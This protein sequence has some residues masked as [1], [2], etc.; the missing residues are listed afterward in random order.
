MTWDFFDMIAAQGNNPAVAVEN[1]PENM[2]F[3]SWILEIFP[4][5]YVLHIIRDP[6]GVWLSIRK[7]LKSWL[8]PAKDGALPPTLARNMT[9]WVDYMGLAVDIQKQTNQYTEVRYEALEENGSAELERLFNWLGLRADKEFC[10]QAIANSALDKMKKEITAPEGFFG[11]GNSNSWRT[12][13]SNSEIKQIEYLAGD[14]MD[15]LGYSRQFPRINR[16]PWQ[17]SLSEFQSKIA[18]IGRRRL[19]RW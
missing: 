6:R 4:E 16:R 15:K 1:T 13:L 7:S 9:T 8:N 11:I 18:G 12:T 19:Y 17:L 2:V 10:E 14:W 5:A 3:L